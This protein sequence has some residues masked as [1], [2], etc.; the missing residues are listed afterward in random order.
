[1]SESEPTTYQESPVAQ[2]TAEVAVK[3]SSEDTEAVSNLDVEGELRELEENMLA[4]LRRKRKLM[5][6]I[7][8]WEQRVNCPR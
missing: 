3:K 5:K 6:K 1:L 8:I 2:G 4:S 7:G